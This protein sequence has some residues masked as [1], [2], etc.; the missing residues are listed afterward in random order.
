MAGGEKEGYANSDAK[1][2]INHNY[3]LC[4]ESFNKP[5]NLDLMRGDLYKLGIPHNILL[6]NCDA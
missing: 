2:F 1:F 3:I 5:E 6:E 4:P